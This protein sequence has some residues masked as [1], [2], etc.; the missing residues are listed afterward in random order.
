MKNG[1]IETIPTTPHNLY[2]L[3]PAKT[4]IPIILA[5]RGNSFPFFYK[6]VSQH[7][8]QIFSRHFGLALFFLARPP[9]RGSWGLDVKFRHVVTSRDYPQ[10]FSDFLEGALLIYAWVAI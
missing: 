8:K 10:I 6:V 9:K 4:G 5:Y 2:G 1:L 7:V 3:I